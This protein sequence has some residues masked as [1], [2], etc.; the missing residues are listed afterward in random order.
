MVCKKCGTKNQADSGFCGKCGE[1]MSVSSE[2]ICNKCN[3]SVAEG[4][5]FCGKCGNKVS[6][7]VISEKCVKCGNII[8]EGLIFCN[9]CGTKAGTAPEPA[10]TPAPQPQPTPAPTPVPPQ[11]TPSNVYSLT[12]TRE[13]A[14][15]GLGTSNTVTVNGIN[16]ILTNGASQVVTVNTQDVLIE[17]KSAMVSPISAKLRLR[18]GENA[19]V[20]FKSQYKFGI[21]NQKLVFTNIFGADV[22]SKSQ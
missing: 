16:Y 14:I 4:M 2:V 18:N 7:P 19:R 1:S 3:A 22:I 13:S 5:S 10:P 9:K 20:N 11:P 21:V 12:V 8:A 17:I 15:I 6:E